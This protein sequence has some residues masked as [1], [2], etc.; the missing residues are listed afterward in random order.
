MR[1]QRP[2][3]LQTA[4][5]ANAKA[6]TQTFYF[7]EAVMTFEDISTAIAQRHYGCSG[8]N[9]VQVKLRVESLLED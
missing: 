2:L 4:P 8:E 6:F 7:D 5:Y 1:F 9:Q 3:S